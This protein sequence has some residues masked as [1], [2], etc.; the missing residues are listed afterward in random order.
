[1]R[2]IDETRIFRINGRF[3][4]NGVKYFSFQ[5]NNQ[6]VSPGLLLLLQAIACLM[7]LLWIT[8]ALGSFVMLLISKLTHTCPLFSKQTGFPLRTIKDYEIEPDAGSGRNPFAED[9]D[10]PIG[11]YT[12]NFTPRGDQGLPNELALCP[13]DMPASKCRDITA[14]ILMRIYTS[15]EQR[16]RAE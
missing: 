10:R 12:I 16:S 11:T 2:H 1:M 6:A 14:V 5:S 13:V 4:T 15:G 8:D 3:L 9:S 7:N